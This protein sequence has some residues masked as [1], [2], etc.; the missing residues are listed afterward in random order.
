MN[1]YEHIEFLDESM[2]VLIS[3]TFSMALL[4]SSCTKTVCGEAWLQHFL[5]SLSYGEYKRVKYLKVKTC[6]NLV[7]INS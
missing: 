1:Y 4:N 5:Q 7:I 6:F 3:E 2:E